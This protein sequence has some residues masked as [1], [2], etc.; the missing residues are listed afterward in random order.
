M[1]DKYSI[2]VLGFTI[3][4]IKYEDTWGVLYGVCFAVLFLTFLYNVFKGGG[5][6]NFDGN[7][8]IDGD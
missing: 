4:A 8:D 6:D 5:G 3:L 7:L 1:I 2:L